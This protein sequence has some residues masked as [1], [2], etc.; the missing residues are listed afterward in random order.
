[1][2]KMDLKLAKVFDVSVDYLHGEGLLQCIN[3][4]AFYEF[5]LFHVSSLLNCS[6]FKLSEFSASL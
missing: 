5:L 6:V 2:H 4:L 1:M 3:N